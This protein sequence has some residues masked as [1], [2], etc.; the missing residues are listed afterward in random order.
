MGPDERIAYLDCG[1]V[2]KNDIIIFGDERFDKSSITDDMYANW[3]H[4]FVEIRFKQGLDQIPVLQEQ[5]E[6]ERRSR[7]RLPQHH[8]PAC[9]NCHDHL[10]SIAS[11]VVEL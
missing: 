4:H 7:A 8:P 9:H 2:G 1:S 6:L 11:S 5:V 3:H 10:I